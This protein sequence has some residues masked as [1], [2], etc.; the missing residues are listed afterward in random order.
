MTGVVEAAAVSRK[1]GVP[2]APFL[3]VL[4]AGRD[5]GALADGKAIGRT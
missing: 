4:S 3:N 1:S 5:G 2:G